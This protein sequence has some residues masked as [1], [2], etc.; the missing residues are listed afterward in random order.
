MKANFYLS[1]LDQAL[2][3]TE[4]TEVTPL[5]KLFEHP[6][7]EQNDIQWLKDN[8]AIAL[9]GEIIPPDKWQYVRIK[10]RLVGELNVVVMPGSKKVF[11]VLA[12]VAAVA[13]TAGIAAF[14]IPF[15]GAGFAAGSLG[16]NLVAAGVGIA[17]SLL[18]S[19]LSAP[20]KAGNTSGDERPSTNAGVS[21]NSVNPLDVLPGVVGRIGFSPSYLA[22]PYTTWDGDQITA[23]A[24]VGCEGRCQID[25]VRVNGLS[26]DDIAGV[27]YEVRE[28][29]EADVDR[30]LFT[31]TVIEERDGITLS[32]FLTELEADKNDALIDQANPENSL[33]QYHYFKT[34]G[35]FDEVVLRFL[36]PSGIVYTPSATAAVVPVRIEMRKVGDVTWRN[37]PVLH[38]ADYRV[39]NGPM[40]TE[41]RIERRNPIAGRHFCSARSEY[42]IIDAVYLT[43]RGQS[44]EY[45]ADPYFAPPLLDVAG[46]RIP[47]IAAF[48]TNTSVPGYTI[49][50]SSN[51]VPG[52][53]DPWRAFDNVS[54][55]TGSWSP[56]NNS[57]S[58]AGSWIQI[59]L[60]SAQIFRS[61]EMSN[62]P[63]SGTT[64]PTTCPT[65]WKVSGS[66]DGSTWTDLDSD[67]IDIRENVGMYGHYQIEN[68]GSYLYYRWTFY[69]NNGAASEQLNVGR[70]IVS[71]EDNIGSVLNDYDAGQ[72]VYV[73]KGAFTE[74]N[75]DTT[76]DGRC[77]YVHLDKRGARVFLRPDL[78]DEGE[79]EIRVK[80]GLALYE[81][82]YSSINPSAGGFGYRYNANETVA[83]Y[84]SYR[85]VGGIN[86][87]YIGQRNYRSDCNIECF[88]TIS[89]DS[90]FDDTNLAMIAVS[91]PNIQ[92][93]SIY[94]RFTKYASV[95]DGGIWQADKVP[96]TNPAAHYRDLLLGAG[97]A[98]PVPG[99]CID[100][101]GLIEWYQRCETNGYESNAVIQGYRVN[102][103]KQ[104]IAS[105]GYAA[106]RDARVY[107]V[108]EDR[109]T[110]SDPIRYL[111]S[112][113]NSKDE[114]NVS[115]IR[116]LPHALRAE[117]NNED[118][119]YAVDHVMVYRD[120][121]N[122][123]NATLIETINY[124]GLTSTSA[125]TAR[126][127]FDLRQMYLRQAKY[128]REVGLEFMGLQRGDVVGLADDTIDGDRAAGWIKS[129]NTSGGN[130]VSITLD[131][132]MPW[133]VSSGI[134]ASA[135]VTSITDILNL[136]EPMGVAIKIP[137][138]D[139]IYKQVSNITDNNVCTFTTPFTDD[140]SL[141]P[142]LLVVCGAFSRPVRRCKV[143]SIVPRGFE[144]RIITL[145]DEA[146]DL[147]T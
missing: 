4:I 36:F 142:D 47:I 114:G 68:P 31:Q 32:G 3:T 77:R 118:E 15:L 39:G 65:L 112:P 100:E 64:V 99:E 62:T 11:A 27:V 59:Q 42:P 40:R 109:D 126:A 24:V 45:S 89:N 115:E 105:A 52:T 58:G 76:T 101:D 81:P 113:L 26:V 60:P 16:A 69:A 50:A 72:G 93:S 84:F 57:L 8:A 37:L 71:T 80:R 132:I 140:G 135:D 95:Y 41:V 103:V 86:S 29:K 7:V 74:N 83:N 137:G 129:V 28:G 46:G 147:Y 124:P 35:N 94:G 106:P 25:D 143:L 102:E 34:S 73:G 70:I 128:S 127:T 30:T 107:G 6:D 97:N 13:L 130:V 21:G 108:I 17:G 122:S 139:L 131:N 96:T 23:H 2:T 12:V 144:R 138:Q 98:D 44:F 117:F 145:T 55:S 90:P 133:S 51:R 63:A 120:G 61:Y 92:L 5:L 123:N 91:A 136:S 66:N 9:D 43:G 19:A 22:P 141:V 119:S 111:I 104:L 75:G 79:Y 85:V 1:P 121:Y 54:T 78:W 87:L 110:S 14:G 88:Q 134:E 67:L 48:T 33:P 82:Y 38:F 56:N 20:P 49:S 53:T 116:R 18:A 146:P 125:V 10:P